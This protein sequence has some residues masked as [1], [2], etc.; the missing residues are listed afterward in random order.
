MANAIPFLRCQNKRLV[1]GSDGETGTDFATVQQAALAWMPVTDT[2]TYASAT[3]IT[4]PTDATTKYA[5]GDRLRLKQGGS[6][7]YYYIITVAATLLTVTGGSDYT[8]AN[9]AITDIGVSK[10]VNPIGFPGAFNYTPTFTGFS[11]DP[12]GVHRFSL[13]GRECRV[14]VRHSTLGTSHP[15]T[16]AA[17]TIT[18]P[19]TAATITNHAWVGSGQ[20]VDNGGIL[21]NSFMVSFTSAATVMNLY[22]NHAAAGWTAALTKGANFQLT[23]EI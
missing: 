13:V 19:I 11:A 21:V 5:V 15:G 10:A 18:L 9:S 1:N 17:F 14:Y 2:W 8:V 16:G 20:G 12:S 3:T 23:Y 22:T 7:K 4:V 6:Y